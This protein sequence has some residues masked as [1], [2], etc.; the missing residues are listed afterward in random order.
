MI[1][2]VNS[3][4]DYSGKSVHDRVVFAISVMQLEL[5]ARDTALNPDVMFGNFHFQ[6]TALEEAER[7][8]VS[9]LGDVE[10]M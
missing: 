4:A 6:S 10:Q 1:E 8:L 7:Q 9:I 3:K 5:M 2:A